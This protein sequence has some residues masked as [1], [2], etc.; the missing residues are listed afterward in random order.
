MK[1]LLL[2]PLLYLAKMQGQ[3]SLIIK[4]TFI[5]I[6]AS[7][8]AKKASI[9]ASRFEISWFLLDCPYMQTYVLSSLLDYT[10][11]MRASNPYDA[12]ENI[13]KELYYLKL[14]YI[15]TRNSDFNTERPLKDK[16]NEKETILAPHIRNMIIFKII[17]SEDE[18][19][20]D[21]IC[22]HIKHKA[23]FNSSWKQLIKNILQNKEIIGKYPNES[24]EDNNSGKYRINGDTTLRYI[25]IVLT[26]KAKLERKE[27]RVYP[28]FNFELESS[29]PN[30]W[31][32]VLSP[33]GLYYKTSDSFFK[34][35][36]FSIYFIEEIIDCEIIMPNKD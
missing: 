17:L 36:K 27:R 29:T 33:F 5:L 30:S 10:Y 16:S 25:K 12:S 6:D 11:I 26:V 4:D 8:S 19:G 9:D 28:D 31:D 18:I 21:S 2:L 7:I 1:I 3:E 35:D 32:Y 22:E 23:S 20:R 14:P 24:S 34:E 13:S 15:D